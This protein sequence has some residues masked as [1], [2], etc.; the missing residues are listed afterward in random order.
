MLIESISVAATFIVFCGIY[1]PLSI[2][3]IWRLYHSAY[4]KNNPMKS[5]LKRQ[6]S[7][8]IVCCIAY[9]IQFFDL[10]VWSVAFTDWF[11][12]E[13]E[14]T[15]IFICQFI[16]LLS[17][18]TFAFTIVLRFWLLHFSIKYES[19]SSNHAWKQMIN[20]EYVIQEKRT[21][22]YHDR[23]YPGGNQHVSNTE[24]ILSNHKRWGNLKF[25]LKTGGFVFGILFIAICFAQ[26]LNAFYHEEAFL[27]IRNG[28]S[29]LTYG[30]FLLIWSLM[31]AIYC[32]T[33]DFY[34][35]I[36]IK[37]EQQHL[38]H[39][40]VGFFFVYII[41]AVIF[42]FS[43]EDVYGEGYFPQVLILFH[44]VA[45]G[46]FIT[47]HIFTYLTLTKLAKFHESEYLPG[48]EPNES[49]LSVVMSSISR[50]ITSRAIVESKDTLTIGKNSQELKLTDVLKDI[51]GFSAF[52][53]VCTSLCA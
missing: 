34:D 30:I 14:D 2:Y 53:K 45:L 51:S 7:L 26:I 11:S 52:M 27:L 36:Y 37:S 23:P 28:S 40:M 47:I 32:R 16:H 48:Q 17:Q 42:G 22:S 43:D 49:C 12:E 9:C 13:T 3:W 35:H 44:C 39:I 31:L 18:F 29:L 25:C 20:P 5:L 19:I 6:T 46:N 33:P 38:F 41:F 50:G 24:W 8:S 21:N 4:R 10:A 1:A 15:I